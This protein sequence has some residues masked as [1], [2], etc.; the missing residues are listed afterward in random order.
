MKHL[1][2]YSPNYQ[3][4]INNYRIWLET[5]GY[6]PSGCGY[7]PVHVQECF[8][9]LENRGICEVWQISQA[10]ADNYFEYLQNRPSERDGQGLGSNYLA[11]HV[12][13][14]RLFLR[15]LREAHQVILNIQTPSIA[16]TEPQRNV[17]TQSEIQALYRAVG[18]RAALGKRDRA[19]LGI[20]YG[21]GLRR[22]EGT[23]LDTGDILLQKSLI[24]VRK[25]KNGRQ[26]YVPMHGQ[27]KA[28]IQA[29]L[30]TGRKYLQ[31]D[32]CQK[33]FFLTCRGARM[34]GQSLALR[35]KGMV[36]R[37]GIERPGAG[38]HTLR[39]SIATHLLQSG[40]SLEDIALFLGHRTLEATQVY[41]HTGHDDRV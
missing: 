16:Q 40:M 6:A 21:C 15:Y 24:Y 35:L 31:R 28:D 41:T 36:S 33:A 37:A 19:M 11:K 7:L 30:K 9:W 39:H 17:F 13:A 14:F 20:Y 26:R 32:I 34:Q 2:V 22:G 29:Y 1:K 25:S 12:Q 38:L 18:D 5:L 23:A 8:H 4:F 10:L 3:Y 27:V